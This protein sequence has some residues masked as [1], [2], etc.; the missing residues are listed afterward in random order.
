MHNEEIERKMN[1]IVNLAR[2]EENVLRT[3]RN[4]ATTDQSLKN[5]IVVVDR[6]LSGKNGK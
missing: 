1:F 3:D 5:L 4:V 6:Y 2:T